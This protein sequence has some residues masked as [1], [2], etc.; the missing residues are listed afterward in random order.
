MCPKGTNSYIIFFVLVLI[1][2]FTGVAQKSRPQLE[3]EKNETQKRI[4]QAQE[5]LSQTEEKKAASLGQL[6]AVRNQIDA[7][8]QLIEDIQNEI[9][10]INEEVND[11]DIVIRSLNKDLEELKE[12]Y[13]EMIY[14]A[15]KA[16]NGIDKMV[17][18]FSSG[19]FRQLWL[20]LQ[21]LNQYTELRKQQAEQVEA[22]AAT[23]ENQKLNLETRKTEKNTLLQDQLREK[24][25]LA[26]LAEKQNTVLSALQSREKELRKEL[27]SRKRTLNSLNNLIAEQI[28]KEMEEARKKKLKDP[29]KKASTAVSSS[30]ESQQQK[31]NWPVET[32]FIAQRFGEQPHPVLK[33]VTINNLGVGI[34]TSKGQQVK[35]VFEGKVT[36]IIKIPNMNTLVILQHGDYRTVYGNL[37]NIMVKVGDQVGSGDI[38]GVVHTN[39]DGIS[40]LE[41]QVW[42]GTQKTDPEKWLVRK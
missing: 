35:A 24:Q 33:R 36:A 34:Q 9:A 14:A 37:D 27:N 38:I 28:R 17:F 40:E 6:A 18:L 32:G 4:R 11:L 2:P 13:A 22:V 23:L 39:P 7:R 3:K 31:L 8:E 16:R 29:E 5:I 30:F 26:G 25:Q 19:T 1:I 12:E 41:F 15:Y 20:R 10:L 21:Y 42:K